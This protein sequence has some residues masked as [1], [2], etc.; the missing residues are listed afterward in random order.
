[1]GINFWNQGEFNFIAE[2]TLRSRFKRVWGGICAEKIISFQL[3][4]QL[5]S[6]LNP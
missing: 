2:E 6:N 3:N 1:M 5:L 4:H